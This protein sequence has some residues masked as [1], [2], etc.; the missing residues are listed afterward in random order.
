MN[1]AG[2]LNRFL[3]PMLDDARVSAQT[4]PDCQ[5]LKLWLL[6]PELLKRPFT[7]DEVERIQKFPAY[8]GFCWAS[9]LVLARQLLQQPH[10]VLGKRVLDFGAGSGVVGIA[11]LMAGAKEVIFCDIDPQALIACEANVHLNQWSKPNWHLHGNLLD[12]TPDDIDL[13]IAADVLYDRAN[14]PLLNLFR[15]HASQVLVADSRIKDFDFPPYVPL[16]AKPAC[17]LPDLDESQEFRS[18]RLYQASGGA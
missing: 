11:A 1:L 8:W 10:W 6:D 9:G 16:G 15:Q 5:G 12:N 18:V 3:Q 7:D 14:L 4:L 17:T 2:E 13:L